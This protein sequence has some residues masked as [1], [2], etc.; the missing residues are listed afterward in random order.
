LQKLIVF[1][2]IISSLRIAVLPL[3]LYSY[4]EGNIAACSIL[5]AFSAATDFF[6]GY[7]ARRLQATSRF[8]AYYDSTTDFILMFGIFAVF[9]TKE[10]YPLWLPLLIAASFFLFLATSHFTKKLY[11]PVGKYIGS[12]LYIGIVLT[13]IFPIHPIFIFVEFA[14]LLFFLVSLG[15][16]I[17]FLATKH[18][19]L[20][21]KLI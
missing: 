3:F 13:L 14:F 7:I 17:V 12:A 5:L 2:A 6:D 16:R 11:D 1:P 8:G 18:H 15:S 19:S 20:S 9:T 21:P 4:N 10:Y